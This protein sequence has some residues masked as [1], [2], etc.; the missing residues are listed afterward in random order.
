MT[1]VPFSESGNNTVPSM[2]DRRVYEVMG[3][4]VD[5]KAAVQTDFEGRKLTRGEGS[6]KI[7]DGVNTLVTPA[8]VT[9][10]WRFGTVTAATVDGA[11]VELK[12]GADGPYVEFSHTGTN[13]VEWK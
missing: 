3:G 7:E 10:R 9:V 11:T 12:T 5:E 1:L 2:D 6:L 8:K 13:L 4:P